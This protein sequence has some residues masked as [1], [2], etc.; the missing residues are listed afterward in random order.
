MITRR[1]FTLGTASLAAMSTYP[2]YGHVA[3]S[4]FNHRRVIGD[5]SDSLPVIGLGNSRS[6]VAQNLDDARRLIDIFVKRGGGYID[7]IGDSRFSVGKLA[8]ESGTEDSIFFGNYVD[9]GLFEKNHDFIKQLID[10]QGKSKLDLLN[11]RDL[12]NHRANFDKYRALKEE[13]L[14][15]YL[16][17]ARSGPNVI[18]P[19]IELVK[20]KLVD[21]V[22][23]N[24]SLI[25]PEAAGRLLPLA[26]DNGVAIVIN[27]PFI[28]GRFF[29]LVR[30]VPLPEWAA[31]FDCASW[32]QF[33]LKYILA[34]PAVN[35]VLTETT[36][37]KHAIDNLGAGRG[38]LPDVAT[39]KRMLEFMRGLL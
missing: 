20:N 35:C 26:K 2:A 33:S 3:G 14:L 38:R 8:T 1:D 15:R 25:E 5:S 28:N 12:R 39:Q 7:L 6:F 32:A 31:D 37:P 16:G 29:D 4:H 27:R 18:D 24:Y 23:V 34:N 19:M 36:N 17:V 30:D 9:V 13:G 22:Q 11:S 10:V 21:F